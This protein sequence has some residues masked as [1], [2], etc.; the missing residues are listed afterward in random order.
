[1][2]W[3]KLLVNGCLLIAAFWIMGPLVNGA[4]LV[5]NG[6]FTE[7]GAVTRPQPVIT[8]PDN[9]I[10]SWDMRAEWYVDVDEKAPLQGAAAL[11]ATTASTGAGQLLQNV[12]LEP[13]KTYTLSAWMKARDLVH[14]G[15][16]RGDARTGVLV[17]N[18]RWTFRAFLEASAEELKEWKRYSITFEAPEPY[19]VAG[20][21]QP[22]IVRLYLPRGETGTI[23]VTGI[24]IEEGSQATD[25]EPVSLPQRKEMLAKL[26]KRLQG[27]EHAA[28]S[29]EQF[30]GKARESYVEN[31][32]QEYGQI[33]NL[34]SHIER[35]DRFTVQ[36][37]EQ[38]SDRAD[39]LLEQVDALIGLSGWW[40]NP[41]KDLAERELPEDVAQF[42]EKSVRLVLAQND[43]GALM[44]PMVN[45][46]GKSVPV[47][48]EVG[49]EV[50]HLSTLTLFE[51]PIRVSSVFSVSNEGFVSSIS[52]VQEEREFP[53]FLNELGNGN[54]VLLPNG[55]VTQLWFDVNTK[56]MEP[57]E[58]RY[59]VKLKGLNFAQTWEGEIIL[60]V[61]PVELPDQVPANVIAFANMPYLMEPFRPHV[62]EQ[63]ILNYTP[64][65]R[66][67]IAKPW[68]QA[69][70]DMGFNRLMLSTQYLKVKF[71][72]NGS[73]AEEVD[74]SVFDAYRELWDSI[75]GKHWIGYSTGAYH[76]FPNWR[77]ISKVDENSKA[78]MRS[79]FK[80]MIAHMEKMGMTPE[81]SPIC[82]FDEPHGIRIEVTRQAVEVLRELGSEWRT[83]SA[84]SG[85]RIDN[86]RPLIP[87]LDI[88]VVR[89]R[90]GQ[91]D[92]QPETIEYL[93]SQ[94]KEVWGYACSGSFEYLNP[95][96]YYRLMP[97]QSW[98]NG[99]QGYGVYMTLDMNAYPRIGARSAYYSPLF[100][101]REGPVYGKGARAFQLG[102]RDWCL[103]SLASDL[104]EQAWNRGLKTQSQE[105]DKVLSESVDRVL[106]EETD[107]S[108]ADEVRVQ[109]LRGIVDM[110]NLLK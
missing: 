27:V 85:V 15:G 42:G 57:G 19:V 35:V 33:A 65:E 60:E 16:E 51:G 75:G 17:T 43:Y 1:M 36:Q 92:M 44:L 98:K 104:I 89:Q 68:L 106:A 41:W 97:W 107:A 108:V 6:D 56:G 29:L 81:T 72:K 63:P 2:K 49:T 59:P 10:P 69:W 14:D 31:L 83:I 9:R 46:S 61:L 11:R 96:R 84:V 73:L 28:R 18:W 20:V 71:N 25:F 48:V 8:R 5:K 32:K 52:P 53:L 66:L 77:T 103:F 50:A 34:K 86:V 45:L 99:L 100:L 62:K 93:K 105:L 87:L 82:M 88:F 23:W 110:Q 30:S 12:Y 76:I 37:W 67:E 109:L 26:N 47:E 78:R 80:S 55:E 91:M 101:G 22:C 79:F 39:K 4:N 3:N 94:G 58:Y 13:G 90:M 64:E 21:E 38:V 40:E 54:T 95:Y 70:Q 102:G 7:R 74:Y 24:Q